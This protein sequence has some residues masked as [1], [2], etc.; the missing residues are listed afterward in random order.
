MTIAL[1]TNGLIAPIQFILNMAANIDAELDTSDSCSTQPGQLVLK[2]GNS[3]TL[4]FLITSGGVRLTKSQLEGVDG[5]QFMVKED[6][7]D[8]DVNAIISKSILNGITILEDADNAPNLRIILLAADT[9]ID[10]GTY[11]VG[12]QINFSSTEVKEATLSTEDK[13]FD[14]ISIA[15]DVVR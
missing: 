5:I 14:E 3:I 12:L 8:D 10:V 1:A 6:P 13:C 11:P 15:Q 9:D 2:K 7:T 4:D